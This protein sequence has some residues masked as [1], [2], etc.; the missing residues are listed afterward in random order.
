MQFN[1]SLI[2]VWSHLV[3]SST[4]ILATHCPPLMT[5]DQSERVY[6][7]AINI[8]QINKIECFVATKN[9]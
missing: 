8:K 2:R 7:C 1:H 5:T 3:S 6:W 9:C 4:V